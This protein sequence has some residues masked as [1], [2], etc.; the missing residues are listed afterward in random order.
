VFLLKTVDRLDLHYIATC[1]AQV[2]PRNDLPGNF[3][4]EAPQFANWAGKYTLPTTPE[5]LGE[6]PRNRDDLRRCLLRSGF[7]LPEP[8]YRLP[9]FAFC[10]S[11]SELNTLFH[12]GATAFYGAFCPGL[13]TA[14]VLYPPL[15]SHLGQIAY[16][17]GL[18]T[19]ALGLAAFL[20]AVVVHTL[21]VATSVFGVGFHS[22]RLKP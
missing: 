18:L 13:I 7:V 15:F 19:N 16:R 21:D 2:I 6:D 3:L 14:L 5:T 17:E 10:L 4:E 20:I 22:L 12:V 11:E 8:R 9:L 1:R